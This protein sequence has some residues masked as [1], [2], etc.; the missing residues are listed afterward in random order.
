MLFHSN[1]VLE[2]DARE[3]DHKRRCNNEQRQ[4]KSYET[5]TK[6]LKP[7]FVDLTETY[8]GSIKDRDIGIFHANMDT[9]G[10]SNEEIDPRDDKQDT[11]QSNSKK[12]S[13]FHNEQR[14]K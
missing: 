6:H 12:D 1:D 14:K 7:V 4:K 9:K 8:S 11:P 10:E 13:K 5:E 3:Y 2:R